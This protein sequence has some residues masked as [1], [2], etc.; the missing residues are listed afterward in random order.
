MREG[1]PCTRHGIRLY[2]TRAC[3]PQSFALQ[4]SLDSSP[5]PVIAHV[6]CSEG[7][8]SSHDSSRVPQRVE[9]RSHGSSL[10]GMSQLIRE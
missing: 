7:Q 10:T 6:N 5:A 1:T 8:P 9:A 2:R 3:Q 4:L